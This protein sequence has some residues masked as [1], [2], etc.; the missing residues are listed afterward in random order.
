MRFVVSGFPND[1]GKAKL[2]APAW[3]A[4]PAAYAVCDA[5]KA[6]RNCVMEIVGEGYPVK[7]VP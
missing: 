6:V 1:N 5:K 7:E 4:F 2:M 3:T